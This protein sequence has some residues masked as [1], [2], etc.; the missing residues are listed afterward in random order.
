MHEISLSLK[1]R[2][3][4]NSHQKNRKNFSFLF[5]EFFAH[6]N[7]NFLFDSCSRIMSVIDL[8]YQSILPL[9]SNYVKRSLVLVDMS[10]SQLL[11][12]VVE[13]SIS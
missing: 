11:W 10:I 9:P 1:W 8:R 3:G 4:L 7:C 13:K 2:S 5:P 12:T 6:D